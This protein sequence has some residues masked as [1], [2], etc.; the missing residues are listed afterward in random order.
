MT[1]DSGSRAMVISRR[2]DGAGYPVAVF[3]PRDA[4]AAG[5]QSVLAAHMPDAALQAR[6]RAGARAVVDRLTPHLPLVGG[7]QGGGGYLVGGSVGR[8]TAVTL[9]DRPPTTDLFVLLDDPA[10]RDPRCA[11]DRLG[12]AL[13]AAG[14]PCRPPS[15]GRT[16]HG[17]AWEDLPFALRPALPTRGRLALPVA[18]ENASL[19]WTICDPLA[20]TAAMRLLNSLYGDRPRQMITLLKVWRRHHRVALSGYGVEILVQAFFRD[21]MAHPGA[22]L[23]EVF[24]AF[25]AWGRNATPAALPL[26]G[27]RRKLVVGEDWHGAAATAYWQA[28]AARHRARTGDVLGSA[29]IWRGLFGPA[30]PLPSLTLAA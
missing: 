28:V 12:A 18:A 1:A 22:D 4:L 26:P 9:T 10:C 17:L 5:F 8:R 3:Q 25:L 23:A 16:A 24:E 14:L 27:G 2:G 15:E 29:E 30:F 21:G 6:L 20:E 7:D 11:V 13:A 19:R